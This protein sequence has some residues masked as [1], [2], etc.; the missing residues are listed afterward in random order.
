[1]LVP[2]FHNTGFVDG[3]AHALLLGGAVDVPGDFATAAALDALARR[4]ASFLVAVPSIVR[5]LVLHGRADDAFARCDVLGYGGASTPPAWRAELAARWPHL[6]LFDLYGLTELTSLTHALQPE[7]AAARPGSVGRP[8]AGIRQRVVDGELW[9]AGPTR[10]LG[11]WRAE[12]ETRRV[13]AGEWLR[14]G[15]LAEIDADGF[16]RL[17]GR[18]AEVINRGGEKIHPIEVEAALA[19]VAA[20][21][22]A[23]VV[24]A[25]HPV[26]GERVVACVTLR[27]GADLDEDALRSQLRDR[28]A[29][30]AIP[31]RFLVVEELP[32]NAAGKVDRALVR[33]LVA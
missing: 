2:L 1:V 30:Y 12:A 5:L 23:A 11:Y 20:V 4:P 29:D 16:V 27:A 17:H 7:D 31:E 6:R 22:E 19:G 9:L 3:V 25:P 13:L 33:E 14:T 28:V 18:A 32:R 24:G 8:V 10:M 15:D 21:A 26:F